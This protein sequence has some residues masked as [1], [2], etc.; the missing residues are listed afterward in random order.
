MCLAFASCS[1]DGAENV[2]FVTPIDPFFE[3]EIP[4]VDLR[5]GLGKRSVAVEELARLGQIAMWNSPDL[6]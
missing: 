4:G 2:A 1:Y 6:K 3:I 5:D